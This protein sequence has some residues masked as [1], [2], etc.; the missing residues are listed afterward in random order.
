L[1]I[2]CGNGL[3][4]AR[5]AP[6]CRAYHGSDLSAEAI[7]S[8]RRRLA[9]AGPEYAHVTL[10]HR[11]ADDLDALAEPAFDAAVI[12]SVIHHFPAIDYLVTVLEEAVRRLRPGGALFIGG[13]R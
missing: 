8:L 13:V 4:L 12:N 5:V 10:D 7:R 11:P 1:E 3:V 6:H 2:G 9:A